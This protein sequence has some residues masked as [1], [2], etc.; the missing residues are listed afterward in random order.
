MANHPA[1]TPY[2]ALTTP[3]KEGIVHIMDTGPRPVQKGP[4]EVKK[5]PILGK[6]L[7][8]SPFFSVQDLHSHTNLIFGL[9]IG[10]R[11]KAFPACS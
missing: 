11:S 1:P 8:V 9:Q 4:V 6:M 2:P 7:M 5:N 10:P 3:S